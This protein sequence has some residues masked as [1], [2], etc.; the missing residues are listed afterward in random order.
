MTVQNKVPPAAARALHE[1]LTA[2]FT[3]FEAVGTGLQLWAYRGGPWEAL[4]TFGFGG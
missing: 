1:Q 2:E 3:P 4:A